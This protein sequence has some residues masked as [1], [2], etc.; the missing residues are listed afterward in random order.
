M[1]KPIFDVPGVVV[2]TWSCEVKAVIGHWQTLRAPKVGAIIT[3]QVA[4][5]A[6]RGALTYVVDLST[7]EGEP[8]P[9]DVTW[10]DDHLPGL[11]AQARI[12]V[13]VT[14][15]TSPARLSVADPSSRP[16]SDLGNGVR[17]YTCTTLDQ[18]LAIGRGVLAGRAA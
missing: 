6:A 10:V 8:A 16:T 12:G 7:T 14:V 9:A 1:E 4:E 15:V 3:R 11:L 5:G 18:A 13:V 2:C 17:A